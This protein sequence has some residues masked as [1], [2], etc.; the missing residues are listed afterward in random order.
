[1]KS[2][3]IFSGSVNTDTF[4]YEI[5]LD[6]HIRDYYNQFR[7]ESDC[8]TFL[9]MFQSS[10]LS[11]NLKKWSDDN[12]ISYEY[13]KNVYD[14]ILENNMGWKVED[15]NIEVLKDEIFEKLYSDRKMKLDLDKELFRDLFIQYISEGTP[16]SIDAESINLIEEHQPL[17]IYG[18]ITSKTGDFNSVSVSYVAPY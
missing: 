7:G 11:D 15:I 8:E 12:A 10:L 9:N 2:P 13:M 14:S 17:E 6:K 5:D 1:M 16:F 4:E 3:F 18:L